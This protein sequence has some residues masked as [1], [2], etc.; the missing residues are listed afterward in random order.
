MCVP[1]SAVYLLW[2][3]SL[4]YSMDDDGDSES[5]DQAL[6]SFIDFSSVNER[7]HAGVVSCAEIRFVLLYI[8]TKSLI[9][10]ALIEVEVL[11]RA[12]TLIFKL[13]AKI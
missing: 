5:C 9:Y 7:W 12:L 10:I 6:L 4:G 1:T 8:V 11:Y 2:K 13:W 3:S